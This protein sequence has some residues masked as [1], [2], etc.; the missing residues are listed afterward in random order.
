MEITSRAQLVDLMRSNGLPLFAAE[1]GVAEGQFSLQLLQA[2]IEKLYLIDIWERM[3]FISGCASFEQEWHDKNYNEVIEK[4]KEYGDKAIIL[5]GLSHKMAEQIPDES[6]GLVYEDS[7]HLY[8]GVKSTIEFYLPKLVKG[9]IF[10]FHDF[11]NEGYGVN[12]A[13]QE[14]TKNEGLFLLPEDGDVNNLGAY[15]I[16]R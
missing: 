3:P 14:F 5:K 12:K 4:T 8:D 13:V 9:G 7:N 2:G 1:V 11:G 15:F 16:K 6:L 10:A